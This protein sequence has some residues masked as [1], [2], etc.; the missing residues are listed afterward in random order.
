MLLMSLV[1][2]HPI[3]QQSA[4]LFHP[5]FLSDPPG[6]FSESHVKARF[7]DLDRLLPNGRRE[8]FLILLRRFLFGLRYLPNGFAI[9]VTGPGYHDR[10]FFFEAA[11]RPPVL[12]IEILALI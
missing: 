8:R 6:F 11:R 4:W 12:A 7:R 3:I 9:D 2:L 5:S 1:V 10:T